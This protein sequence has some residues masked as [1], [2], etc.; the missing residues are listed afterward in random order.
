[1]RNAIFAV[2]SAIALAGCA[3]SPKSI[4]AAYISPNQYTGLSCK[5]L[6]DEG[7]R[8]DAA[9]TQA[10]AQQEQAHGSDVASVILI[11]VP[12]S[13]LSG[14]NVA[15]Q[16]ASLKG[17]KTQFIWLPSRSIAPSSLSADELRA[18]NA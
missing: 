18:P 15:P 1:M 11:G 16:V 2:A 6:S 8:A 13:T 17:K 12:V 4:S 3:Q 14:S 7:Q 5:E 10:S 9:L